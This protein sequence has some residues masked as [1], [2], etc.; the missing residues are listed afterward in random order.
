MGGP[1]ESFLAKARMS[2]ATSGPPF[3]K[4]GAMVRYHLPSYRK[5]MA[6]RERNSQLSASNEKP[7][8]S[9]SDRAGADVA[10]ALPA[11]KNDDPAMLAETNVVRHPG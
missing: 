8:R 11:R 9:G 2:G 7:Q 6:D 1:S 3:I 10:E 4:I 5:W